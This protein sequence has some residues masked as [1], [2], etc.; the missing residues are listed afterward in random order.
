MEKSTI[1]PFY[2]FV[3][4]ILCS[5]ISSCEY[6]FIEVDLPDSNDYVSLT[7]DIIPIFINNNKCTA[8]HKTGST[9]PD[10]TADK[11]YQSIVPKLINTTDPESSKIYS[12]P[13][14]M[15]SNHS[16]KKY[17]S[18]EAALVLAWIKQGALNN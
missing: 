8:C 2:L 1:K 12:T 7:A 10:L 14:P 5:A 17:T 18:A 6:E 11:A 15:S 16:F 9:P 3:L 4:I 13:N